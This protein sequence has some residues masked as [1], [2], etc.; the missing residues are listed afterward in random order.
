MT[1]RRCSRR[2]RTR[3]RRWGLGGGFL[4]GRL[5]RGGNLR[6][7]ELRVKLR[8]LRDDVRDQLTDGPTLAELSMGMSRDF[9]I[10]I[11][12]GATIVRIGSTLFEGIDR[13]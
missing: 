6:L 2:P 9:E 8:E 10:A 5:A 13:A 1:K 12:E 11:E 3:V 4:G 7:E